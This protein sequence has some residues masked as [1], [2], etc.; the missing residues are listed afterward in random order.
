MAIKINNVEKRMSGGGA[1]TSPLDMKQFIKLA[2]MEKIEADVLEDLTR[3]LQNMY[4]KEKKS[5][6]SFS[7]WL[8]SKPID[9]LKRIE[10]S[11]GGSV[12]EKYGDLIDAY[13][14]KIDVMPGESLTDYINRIRK[15]ELQEKM[16]KN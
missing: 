8:K 10:L 15:A 6:Q 14:K 9:E 3:E 7:D 2:D 13:E 5:G 12:S 1:K 4:E 16:R 11:N